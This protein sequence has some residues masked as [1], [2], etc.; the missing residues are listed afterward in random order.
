M[1]REIDSGLKNAMAK[2]ESL[3]KAM[4]SFVNA[5]Y[6]PQEVQEAGQR[7]SSGGGASAIIEHAPENKIGVELP[8]MPMKKKKGRAILILG[9]IFAIVVL[10]GAA[11]YLIYALSV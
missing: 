8:P 5:G 9:I 4:K 3:E 7:L 2:G 10:L 11:G 1:N 6:N